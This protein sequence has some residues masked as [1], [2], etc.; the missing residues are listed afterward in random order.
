MR[1]LEVIPAQVRALI[2]AGVVL[3]NFLGPLTELD[4]DEELPVVEEEEEQQPVHVQLEG[5]Q[6]RELLCSYFWPMG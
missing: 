5:V 6:V 4:G 2:Y 3:H 1:P